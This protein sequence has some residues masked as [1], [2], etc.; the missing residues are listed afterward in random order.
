VPLFSSFRFDFQQQPLQNFFR[1]LSTEEQSISFV[2]PPLKS[3]E[4][5]YGGSG[6][7]CVRLLKTTSPRG[8]QC[9]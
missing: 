5:L 7:R 1:P 6:W 2:M 4:F 9:A 3:G 8:K